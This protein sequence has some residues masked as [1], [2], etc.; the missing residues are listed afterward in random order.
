MQGHPYE[1]FSRSPCREK[2]LARCVMVLLYI[3]K[4]DIELGS[5]AR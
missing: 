1:V 5:S 2:P 4:L 3:A